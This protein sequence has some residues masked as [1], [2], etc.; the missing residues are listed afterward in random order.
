MKAKYGMIT[1]EGRGKLGGHIAS[2]NK[3]GA[4]F[5]NKTSS[6]QPRTASQGSQKNFLQTISQ[7]WFQLTEAQREQWNSAVQNFLGTNIWGDSETPSGKSLYSKLNLNLLTAGAALV[8]SPP[9]PV[10]NSLPSSLS[11]SADF[12]LQTVTVTFD[13]PPIA[14][15]TYVLE[16]TPGLSPGRTFTGSTFRIIALITEF[17]VSPFDASAAYLAKFGLVPPAG[18][19][20]FINLTDVNLLTGEKS[21]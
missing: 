5:K 3:S 21:L 14:G 9:L 16:A 17:D 1:V 2:R 20:I 19:K 13:A 15:H 18:S 8:S 7:N 12:G 10:G 6:V 11:V 4:Y